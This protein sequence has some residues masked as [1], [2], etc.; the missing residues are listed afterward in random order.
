V[1]FFHKE[2]GEPYELVVTD[3]TKKAAVGYLLVPA[4]QD[5]VVPG[6][7]AAALVS[8]KE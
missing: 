6:Q 4:Q 2:G 3:V 1:R 5:D 7:R 8:G